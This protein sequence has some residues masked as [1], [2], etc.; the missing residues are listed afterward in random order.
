M[1]IFDISPVISKDLQVWPGDQ[2]YT[3][4]IVMSVDGGDHIGLSRITSTLH[5][6][7][8]VDA[9]NHYGKNSPGIDQRA[10]EN[11]LGPVQV[12]TVSVPWG[13]RIY[14]QHLENRDIC[15]PRLLFKTES[16][17]N[18]H[19]W[20]EDFCALSAELVDHL[21]LSNVLLL[22]IDTPSVDLFDDK[23]LESH[24]RIH[25]HNMSIL[26][27]VDLSNVSDG[28]YTLIALPL[29]LKD[30]DASPV[31]AVLIAGGLPSE[32]GT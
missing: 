7:A 24:S 25:H 19:Q 32:R 18:P 3:R 21:A 8:H 1:K 13:E 30:A 6:G 22:G 9:P 15:A 28:V 16:F 27:G 2:P 26:E 23:V 10:L 4:E 17:P 12:I 14:P 5:L 20:N 31:R 11:Y 29:P